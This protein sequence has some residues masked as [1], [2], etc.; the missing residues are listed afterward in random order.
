MWFVVKPDRNFS[1]NL[2]KNYICKNC[3][4]KNMCRKT[5]NVLTFLSSINES[6]VFIAAK[7]EISK[8]CTP[9]FP[10]PGFLLS[11]LGKR[12]VPRVWGPAH[13]N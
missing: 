8:P 6:I 3:N 2:C 7:Q 1:E 12:G 4:C 13:A 5:V 11:A 9:L 10:Q